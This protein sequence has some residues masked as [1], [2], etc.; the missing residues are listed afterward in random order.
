MKIKAKLEPGKVAIITG[1]SSGIGKEIACSLAERGMDIWLVA[2]RKDL[3]ETARKEVELHRHNFDQKIVTISADISDVDQ[4]KK[5]VDQVTSGSG[6]PDL[7]VNSAGVAHPG[8]VQDLDINIFSWMMEVNYFGTVFMTKAVLPAMIKRNSGYILNI[9]S[10][11][12]FIGTFGYTAY[13]ASKF[14]VNGFS[15]ALRAEMKSHGI[16]VSVVF[17]V[18]TETSQLEYENR[19][20]PLETR[21]LDTL[22][23]VMSAKEVAK[24]AIKGIERGWYNILPGFDSKLLYRVNGTFGTELSYIMD[25]I[26]ARAY[27]FIVLL[28]RRINYGYIRK[29]F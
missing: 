25:Q 21:A 29:M 8:Y 13:G 10:V 19:Y 17:P 23:K 5:V 11:A 3:L 26:A 27:G 7:L 2:Q 20:K 24:E 6:V 18:D 22:T 14:A 16:G 15:A 1:G 9:S 4:V 12:G 28:K